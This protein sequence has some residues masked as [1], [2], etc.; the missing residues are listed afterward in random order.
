[1]LNCVSIVLLSSPPTAQH[2]ALAIDSAPATAYLN[3][4]DYHNRK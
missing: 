1:M 2:S 4:L 3:L